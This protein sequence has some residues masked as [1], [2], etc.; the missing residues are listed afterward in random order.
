MNKKDVL[1]KVSLAFGAGI[2]VGAIWFWTLQVLD[3]MEILSLA[4]G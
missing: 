4:A 3:V 2:V 1:E